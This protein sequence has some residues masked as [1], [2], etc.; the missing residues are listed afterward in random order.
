MRCRKAFRLARTTRLSEMVLF[1]AVAGTVA[2]ASCRVWRDYGEVTVATGDAGQQIDAES[3]SGDGAP[4]TIELGGG[5]M[6]KSGSICR[7]TTRAFTVEAEVG[8]ILTAS[9]DYPVDEGLLAAELHDGPPGADETVLEGSPVW[10]DSGVRVR[11]FVTETDEYVVELS[12]PDGERSGPP[13]ISYEIGVERQEYAESVHH[14]EAAPASEDVG[15]GTASDPW[16]DWSEA[17]ENLEPG[18]LL[19]VG[20]GTWSETGECEADGVPCVEVESAPNIDCSR[21]ATDGEP[22]RPIIIAAREE[23]SATLRGDGSHTALRLARCEH[24]E[25]RGLTL[26]SSKRGGEKGGHGLLARGSSG[27]LLR[28]LLV[29]R[30]NPKRDNAGITFNGCSDSRVEQTEVYDFGQDGIRVS[31]SSEVS[32]EETYLRAAPGGAGSGVF[33]FRSSRSRFANVIVE[34]AEVGFELAAAGEHGGVTKVGDSHAIAGSVVLDGTKGF[35]FDARPDADECDGS[36]DPNCSLRHNTIEDSVVIGSGVGFVLEGGADNRIRHASVFDVLESAYRFK[37][38]PQ[39][40]GDGESPDWG[41]LSI[42]ESLAV[43]DSSFGYSVDADIRNWSIR[44]VN[45]FGPETP[46][47]PA[48]EPGPGFERDPELGGCR[49]Y[50]PE[51]SPMT[52]LNGTSVGANI[53]RRYRARSDGE[54]G[55]WQETDERLWDQR[56]GQFPCG[57]VISGGVNDPSSEVCANVHERLAVGTD[58]CPI[59]R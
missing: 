25:V 28:R 58:A 40:S 6:Q 7:G 47:D 20:P 15:A 14:L 1:A 2:L 4:G 55:Y 37:S 19:V 56:N 51:R 45:A 36:S 46:Y 9:V 21:D 39:P 27:L 22:T 52:S 35:E 34:G 38:G 41:P 32:I 57:R 26:R 13:R 42:A 31:Q 12:Y 50:V 43:G 5:E 59:P 16:T 30:P 44:D 18:D 3:C 53:V 10:T 48:P 33:G 24:W 17:V 8:E 23:R 54:E 49:V 11:D 29:D